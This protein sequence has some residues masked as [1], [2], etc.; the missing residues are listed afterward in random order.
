MDSNFAIAPSLFEQLYII[1]TP[2][3][4][5]YVTCAYALLSGKSHPEYVDL[6]TVVAGKAALR[7][8]Y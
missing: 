4:S 7:V 3:A 5:S 1:R 8:C 2:L 6:L